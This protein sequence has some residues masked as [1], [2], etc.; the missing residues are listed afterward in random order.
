MALSYLL[1]ENVRGGGLWQAL[2]LHNARGS[3]P[4]AVLRVGDPPD[5]PLGSKDPDILKWCELEDR[6]LVSLDRSTV[7][8]DLALH[9]QA[10]GHSPGV[11]LILKNSKSPRSWRPWCLPVMPAIRLLFRIASSTSPEQR[12]KTIR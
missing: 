5:L 8:R 11:F 9:L 6:I 10:G 1:D 2:G 7:P 3:F 4:V 12:P